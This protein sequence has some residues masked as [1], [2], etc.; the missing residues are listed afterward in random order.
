MATGKI[1]FDGNTSAVIFQ[2]ILDRNPR[3]PAELNPDIPFKLEEIIDKA[4]EKDRDLR[5]QSAAELRSDLKRL[6]RD[7][8]G[9]SSRTGHRRSFPSHKPWQWRGTAPCQRNGVCRE[10]A[11]QWHQSHSGGQLVDGRRWDLWLLHPLCSVAR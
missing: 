7:S 4:L 3:P 9:Q 10:A 11:S 5:Y 6:K 1:A 8:S 2:G